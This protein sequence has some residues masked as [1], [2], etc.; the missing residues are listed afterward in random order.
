MGRWVRVI[1]MMGFVLA[2]PLFPQ[3]VGS[4]LVL[5]QRCRAELGHRWISLCDKIMG[6]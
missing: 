2:N 6:Y 5:F 1:P 3:G 4:S